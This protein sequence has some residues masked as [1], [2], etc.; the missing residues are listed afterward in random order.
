[1]EDTKI[2]VGT[3]KKETPEKEIKTE[4]IEEKD[5]Q[6]IVAVEEVDVFRAMDKFDDDIIVSELQGLAKT[7]TKWV[8]AFKSKEGVAHFELTKEGID[9]G[10]RQLTEAQKAFMREKLGQILDDE[11][12]IKVVVNVDRYAIA[13]GGQEALLDSRIGAKRQEKFMWNKYK[14]KFVIDPFYFEKCIQK[15][16]RNAN[17]RYIPT[18]MKNA[19]VTSALSSNKVTYLNVEWKEEKEEEKLPDQK[20]PSEELPENAEIKKS[21]HSGQPGDKYQISSKQRGYIYSLYAGLLDPNS[22]FHT[23][24]TFDEAV[25]KIASSI[26]YLHGEKS[27]E[28]HL[29]DGREVH[30]FIFPNRD[31]FQDYLELLKAVKSIGKFNDGV[32][33]LRERIMD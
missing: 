6:Q 22:K 26:R 23:K 11:K 17:K 25:G 16:I 14:K 27:I 2:T 28:T 5:K 13:Q 21:V 9:E 7:E 31:S 15:A 12:D 24:E 1:M 3:E 19:I 8:Y 29:V 18:E 30:E 10:I 4:V 20:N 32:E 33:K